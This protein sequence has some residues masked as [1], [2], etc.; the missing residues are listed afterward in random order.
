[1]ESRKRRRRLN[2]Q[3][4]AVVCKEAWHAGQ[5]LLCIDKTEDRPV[6]GTKALVAELVDALVSGTSG[7]SRGGSSPLLGTKLLFASLK[8]F[9]LATG[10]FPSG[11]LGDD[12]RRKLIFEKRQPVAQR[13]F[14]LLEPLDLQPVAGT[15][16]EQCVDRGIEVAMLLTQT[17]EFGQQ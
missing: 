7:E 12:V 11:R 14:S 10:G 3:C 4:G 5:P 16:M 13:E 15:K 8:S 2:S 9:K 1:M 6:S 17:L